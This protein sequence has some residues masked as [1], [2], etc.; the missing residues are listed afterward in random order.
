MEIV[1]LLIKGQIVNISVKKCKSLEDTIKR[2]KTIN[3]Y[4]RFLNKITK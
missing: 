4:K 2:S 1:K 3:K